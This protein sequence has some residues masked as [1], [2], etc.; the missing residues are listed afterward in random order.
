MLA[1]EPVRSGDAAFL[2][3]LGSKLFAHS[4][5]D[6]ADRRLARIVELDPADA[7]GVADDATLDRAS[8]AQR[9][10]DWAGAVALCRDLVARWPKS[11][12]ADDATLSAAWFAANGGMKKEAISGYKE[13]LDR[14]PE[15]DDADFARKEL[16]TLE[17]SAI[18]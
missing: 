4:R 2:Y 17:G 18:D 16:R 15:G 12:L 6:E 9:S 10:K 11:D 14:W 7:S 13:Y 8:V 3:S 5:Y 1:E